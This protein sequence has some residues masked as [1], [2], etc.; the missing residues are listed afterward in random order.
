[1]TRIKC[2]KPH[3]LLMRLSTMGDV[4]MLAHVVKALR[5]A[6]PELRIT[7]MT[8]PFYRPFFRDVPGGVEFLDADPDGRHRGLAGLY[9]LRNDMDAV[10]VTHVVDLHDTLRTRILGRMLRGRGKKVAKIDAGRSEKRELT[11]K[12][13]K[14]LQ[15]LRPT[16]ERYADAVRGL[17]FRLADL[18]PPARPKRPVPPRI[19]DVAGA[20]SGVWV[21]VAPFARYKG[22]IY[23]TGAT[24][25]MI[26]ALAARYRRVFIFGGGAYEKDFAEHM[27]RQHAGVVSVIGRIRLDAELDLIANLDA[28][29]SMDS[30]AMHMASL[31]GVPVISV[32][33]ATHPYAGSYGFGQDAANAV[34]LEMH[35]R[36]CSAMGDRAC[37]HRN[38]R[39]LAQITPEMIVGRVAKICDGRE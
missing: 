27:E 10:G 25:D 22:K 39:C 31:V 20:K 9:R 35:C 30:S 34:Q 13:R 26:A 2:D 21:G 37:M 23:P 17:G 7:V 3:L 16:V 19:L 11:R 24:N 36:P 1:M 8:R 33:G 5:G 18:T 28:M 32:W 29:V 12:F 15:Q 38:Y 4:A 14:R 6:E